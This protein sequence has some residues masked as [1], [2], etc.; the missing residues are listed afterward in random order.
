M[1]RAVHTAGVALEAA[2]G[3]LPLGPRQH[4]DSRCWVFRATAWPCF[5]MQPAVAT[6]L[7]SRFGSLSQQVSMSG[8]DARG[9]L[10]EA[11]GGK[12]GGDG[13]GGEGGGGDGGGDGGGGEGGGGGG[14]GG[15]SGGGG[16]DGAGLTSE[17]FR[18]LAR[19]TSGAM[20]NTVGARVS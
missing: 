20:R 8:R 7:H 17:K 16:G 13:G 9:G 3:S 4:L 18:Q 10:G 15:G 12:G 6:Q 14:G 2:R 5:G 1:G 19:R 11:G